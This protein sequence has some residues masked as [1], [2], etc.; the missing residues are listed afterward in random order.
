MLSMCLLWCFRLHHD[1]L[2]LLLLLRLNFRIIWRFSVGQWRTFSHLVRATFLILR[3]I[4]HLG[5]HCW[6]KNY[7]WLSQSSGMIISLRLIFC[8]LGF[9][10]ARAWACPILKSHVVWNG[11]KFLRQENRAHSGSSRSNIGSESQLVIQMIA[12]KEVFVSITCSHLPIATYMRILL[13][14]N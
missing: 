1:L 8:G 9:T 13:S 2:Y 7:V 4:L 12:L 3:R 14:H 10:F 5:I 6:M 11:R